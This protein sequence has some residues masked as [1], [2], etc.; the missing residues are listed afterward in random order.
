MKIIKPAKQEWIAF[1]LIMPL[2]VLLMNYLLFGHRLLYDPL[3]LIFSFPVVF[4]L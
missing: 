1:V 3:V 2:L 4:V